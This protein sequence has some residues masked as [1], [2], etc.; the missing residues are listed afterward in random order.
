MM[1]TLRRNPLLLALALLAG[2]LAVVLALELQ[3]AS[4]ASRDAPAK[5]ARPVEAKLL[6]PIAPRPPEQAYPEVTA[7]PLF[8]ST[9]R[10]APE[11]AAAAPA[12]TMVRG[13]FTL[14]GVIVRGDQ[15]TAMLRERS[16]GKVVRA[17]AGRELNGMKVAEIQ[18]ESV[19]LALGDER[20]VLPLAVQK[21]AG[22]NLPPGMA[23]AGAQAAAA[24]AMAGAS[25]PFARSPAL[26]PP[27]GAG[28]GNPSGNVGMPGQPG[29]PGAVPGAPVP[30]TTPFGP[31]TAAGGAAVP[32][33]S[34]PVAGT[35][36]QSPTQAGPAFP[37]SPEELLARR[38]ARRAQQNQ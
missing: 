19:T 17:E 15:R 23:G 13:Q 31:P 32:A 34:A 14:Q 12:P 4:P 27:Q 36:P 9:R 22:P 5:A 37:M 38:R 33:P 28:Q 3:L 10:P 8:V 21:A 35:P 30:A 25:G 26:M 6:P 18:V 11:M 16:T 29:V 2:V 7:R 24:A 20:E 1:D